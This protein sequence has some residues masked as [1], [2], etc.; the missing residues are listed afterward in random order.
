MKL[1]K[2]KSSDENGFVE[3]YGTECVDIIVKTKKNE[4]ICACDSLMDE[5]SH[6]KEFKKLEEAGKID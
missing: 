5:C 1:R 2:P 6:I 4:Y 3:L